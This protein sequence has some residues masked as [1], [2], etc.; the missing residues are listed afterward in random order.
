MQTSSYWEQTGLLRYDVVIVGAGIIGL[1]TAAELLE[2]HPNLSVCVVERGI[3][4]TGATTR[5]A[6][7]ACMGSPTEIWSD[8][9]RIGRDQTSALIAERY[10]GL[11]RLRERLGPA[12]IGYEHHGGYEILGAEQEYILEHCDAINALAVDI[13]GAPLCV[14]DDKVISDFGFSPDS[15]RHILHLP[16]EGQIHSGLLVRALYRY[17]TE[18]GGMIYTG[19]PVTAIEELSAVCRV[20]VKDKQTTLCVEAQCVAVC[21]NAFMG[22]LLPAYSITPARGQIL[23]T[24]PIPHLPFRGVFH[25]DEGYLYFRSVSDGVEQRVLLG[26]ARN[27][28]FTEEE[29]YSFDTTTKIQDRLEDILQTVILPRYTIGKDFTVE[30]RWSGLMGF[31]GT[32]QPI[33]QAVSDRMVVG[34]ACNGMGVALGT[35]AG[36]R[37]ANFLDAMM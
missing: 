8:I 21:T 22:E 3:L 17:I 20:V 37:I 1:S 18:R 32:K 16:F 7:F 13:L 33:I 12:S 27:D 30:H 10:R 19:C 31:S 23:M 6:G 29:T 26:G 11:V 14:Y 9:Q 4:P 35:S 15:V 34:F 28:A 25:A 24:S 5:N 36:T 2:R